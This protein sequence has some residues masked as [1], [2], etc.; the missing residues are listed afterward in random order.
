VSNIKQSESGLVLS[1]YFGFGTAYAVVDTLLP[2]KAYWV[3]VSGTGKLYMDTTTVAKKAVAGIS[4]ILKQ[5]NSLTITDNTG[6]Q[7]IL[8]FGQAPNISA[9]LF[10][11]P[12]Q[13][14][15]MSFDV[16]FVSNRFAEP[17]PEKME[18]CVE[19][20]F[21]IEAKEYPLTLNWHITGDLSYALRDAAGNTRLL[22]DDG[23]FIISKP[24][25]QYAIQVN[26]TTMLP[27]EFS[28]GDNYPNPFNPST[29]FIVAVPKTAQVELV[30]YDIL[31]K[32]VRTIMNGEQSA[33]YHTIEWNGLSDNQTTV[34]SGFYFVR[35]VSEKFT[36]IKKIMMVK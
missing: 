28:L 8:Y 20:P 10:E 4:D 12:P 2:G 1:P 19:F 36:A 11:L 17:L 21:V 14:P 18:K 16:R 31:G 3:K 23:S 26:G 27:T 22:N 6:R 35:M 24:V 30:V 9:S 5:M 25:K 29:K 34:S 13:A 32:V 15:E 33:G 7:Q